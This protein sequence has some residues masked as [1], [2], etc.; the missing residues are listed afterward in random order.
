MNIQ[1]RLQ[2]RQAPLKIKL[3]DNAIR[4]K[5]LDVRVIRLV[6]DEDRYSNKEREII[7]SGIVDVVIKIPGGDIQAFLG[8]RNNNDSYTSSMSVYSMLPIEAWT[9]SDCNLAKGDILIFKILT[10]PYDDPTYEV[11]LQ[12]L[13]VTNIGPKVSNTL[14]YNTYT[15]APYSFNIEQ[16]PDIEQLFN[17]YKL[18]PI[19]L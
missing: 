11:V 7:D 19:E 16:E 14:L 3:F 10:K 15:V 6:I 18:E 4:K 8:Q 2:Y 5:A 9:T 12:C 1:S 17:Q 13:Q